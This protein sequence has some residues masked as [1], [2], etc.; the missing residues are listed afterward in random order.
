FGCPHCG[1]F[2]HTALPHIRNEYIDRGIVRWVHVPLLLG[3]FPGSNE[4]ASAAAC[5]GEQGELIYW[6]MHDQLFANQRAWASASERNEVFMAYARAAG[7]DESRFRECLA[8]ERPAAALD[9]FRKATSAVG[10]RI[11]PTFVVN[12]RLV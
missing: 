6:A 7:A 10:V 5:A 1:A 2:M 3:T 8:S 4:A 11:A 12:G 9:R